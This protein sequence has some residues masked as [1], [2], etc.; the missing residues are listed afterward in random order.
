MPNCTSTPG[1]C[2]CPRNYT[3]FKNEFN[4]EEKNCLRIFSEKMSWD[5]ATRTC[6]NE[7]SSLVDYRIPDS[8]LQDFRNRG[9]PH[10]SG[11]LDGQLMSQEFPELRSYQKLLKP[12]P[13]KMEQALRESSF[14]NITALFR[15]EN[16]LN[17]HKWL[18]SNYAQQFSVADFV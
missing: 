18:S 4:A 16:H 1:K 7:F 12:V 2:Q 9:T 10:T 8:L 13:N 5:A 6:A 3:S 11:Y 15:W 17:D 14:L